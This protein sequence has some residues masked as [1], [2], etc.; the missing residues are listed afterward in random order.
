MTEKTANLL[1]MAEIVG[2]H[3]I[4]G[5]VKLKVFT[6]DPD[7]LLD[8]DLLDANGKPALRIIDIAQHGNIYLADID[9]VTDRNQSEKLRGTKF[10]TPR[11]TLPAIKQK[12]T[13]YHADLVGMTAKHVDGNTLG[14]I[15]AVTNFGAG[16]LL[17]IKPEKGNS[18]YVPFT[19]TV[20]P[21][22]D[23]KK[24]EL[25]IDPPEGLLN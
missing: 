20:V 14:I 23:L 7:A 15:I 1:L 9:G 22:V 19:N 2:V 24:K 13:Y 17:D 12:D 11:D 25:T 8:A 16:D 3:G 5:A 6:D 10:F 4:K 21:K 18:F